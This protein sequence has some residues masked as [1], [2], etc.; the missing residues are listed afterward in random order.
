MKLY[1]IL[2]ANNR[3]KGRVWKRNVTAARRWAVKQWGPG[4]YKVTLGDPTT[5]GAAGGF[6]KIQN[7]LPLGKTVRVYAKR[8]KNGKIE[9]YGYR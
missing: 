6:Q 4:K 1:E 3:Y 9:L 7:P 8:L 5:T 2:D